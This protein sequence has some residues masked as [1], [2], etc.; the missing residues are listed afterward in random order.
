MRGSGC[1]GSG[2]VQRHYS[3]V[4][5]ERG[6]FVL[7]PTAGSAD[8]LR[9]APLAREGQKP[10]ADECSGTGL[11][12]GKRS[13]VTKLNDAP[14]IKVNVPPTGRNYYIVDGEYYVLSYHRILI[15][16]RAQPTKG[17]KR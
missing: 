17:R 2:L 10:E 16:H 8:R 3:D 15:R 5:P 4:T 9:A 6:L 14:A 11:G 13:E 12:D 7:S 1:R